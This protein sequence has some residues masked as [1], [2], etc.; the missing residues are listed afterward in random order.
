MASAIESKPMVPAS[1]SMASASLASA[2]DPIAEEAAFSKIREIITDFSDGRGKLVQG[3]DDILKL[4]KGVSLSYP[5]YLP[6]RSVGVHPENRDKYGL[7]TEDVHGLGKDI[8][9]MGFSESLCAQALAIEEA[10]GS[11]AFDMFNIKLAMGNERLAPVEPC[12]LKFASLACSHTNAFLR[13][14]A[15]GVPSDDPLVSENGFFCLSKVQRH[16]TK[17]A[18]AVARGLHWAVLKAE[19]GKRFPELPKLLQQAMNAPASAC[20]LENEVQVMMSIQQQ[21]AEEQQATGGNPDYDRILSS[22]ARTKPPCL[23]DLKDLLKFVVC[24]SGGSDGMLLNDLGEFHREGVESEKR[25][26][27]GAFFQSVADWNVDK[28]FFLK[29]ALV[30]TQYTCPVK[31]VCRKECLYITS[32]DMASAAKDRKPDIASAES[33]L[34][35]FRELCSG[36]EW[37]RLTAVQRVK[38]LAKI[39]VTVGRWLMG[40]HKDLTDNFTGFAHIVQH[41]LEWGKADL[42][43]EN[44]ALDCFQKELEA[45]S[46]PVPQAKAESTKTV[47]QASAKPVPQDLKLQEM[48]SVNAETTLRQHKLEIG[49]AVVDGQGQVVVIL[50]TRGEFVVY[51]ASGASAEE[52][53][54]EL[55]ADAFVAKYVAHNP[56]EVLHKGWPGNVPAE[57]LDHQMAVLRSQAILA[58]R[59]ASAALPQGLESKVVVMSKPKCVKASATFAKGALCL[60]PETANI[61]ALSSKGIVVGPSDSSLQVHFNPAIATDVRVWLQPS[62]SAGFVC[63]AWHVEK[64]SSKTSANMSWTKMVVNLCSIVE[65][66][67]GAKQPSGKKV[68]D[69]CTTVKVTIPILTNHKEVKLGMHLAVF[70]EKI[71]AAVKRQALSLGSVVGVGIKRVKNT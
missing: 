41:V 47:P 60:V 52:S 50:S 29:M 1:A 32:G 28:V 18:S 14:I 55:Q 43:F 3:C 70:E 57:S 16:D 38:F 65:M 53:E 62:A 37:A 10:D 44:K 66:V 17:L 35:K 22:V 12:S 71:T 48:T 15:A 51:R 54:H 2:V 34:K 64:V 19:V 59:Q 7:N 25:T 11:K 58:L 69:A 49:M 45:S 8:A 61:L 27:R 63:P 33:V 13:C 39:D 42:N 9:R 36:P 26:V 24:C 20:R 46:K 56:A 67:D 31:L 21:A 4:L 6:P 5:S 30:K 23:P 40:K 68:K